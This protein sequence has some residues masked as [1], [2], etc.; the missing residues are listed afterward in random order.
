[1]SPAF[2]AAL[3]K[4]RGAALKVDR[5]TIYLSCRTCKAWGTPRHPH[6]LLRRGQSYLLHLLKLHSSCL[7]LHQISLLLISS[8]ALSR[9][10]LKLLGLEA[11][12][13]CLSNFLQ[14]T[15]QED[16]RAPCN[17]RMSIDLHNNAPIQKSGCSSHT[18]VYGRVG[19]PRRSSSKHCHL[20]SRLPIG[21]SGLSTT[22]NFSLMLLSSTTSSS[23]TIKGSKHTR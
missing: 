21:S 6:R 19:T 12:K 2:D 4:Q 8:T 11:H 18:V 3:A 1:M 9:S 5:S 15:D 7:H 23:T 13:R 17:T 14:A 16:Q 20:S 22:P 10:E